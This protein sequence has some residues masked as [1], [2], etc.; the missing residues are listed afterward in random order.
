MPLEKIEVVALPPAAERPV[1]ALHPRE[2][3]PGRGPGG[4]QHRRGR[5]DRRRVRPALGRARRRV[6]CGALR[7]RRPP[8]RASRT[9]PTTSRASSGWRRTGRSPPAPAPGA[10]RSSS[11][12][13]ARTTPVPWS[14]PSRSSPTAT[15]NLTRI[16]S[17]PLR[18][19]L[20]RYQ[21]FIDIEGASAEDPLSGAIETLRSKAE[22]GAC[23]GQ[24]ADLSAARSSRI[25]RVGPALQSRGNMGN[26]A[27]AHEA[28]VPAGRESSKR[29]RHRRTQRP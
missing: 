27:T 8:P 16:E 25:G 1:R 3:P 23:A 2:P 9:S 12:S 20:G 21:F 29:P 15:I 24:L 14:T 11:R 4:A 19:G 10:P 28:A 22:I 13:S 5:A 7:C 26:G 18:R 17:R 6:G